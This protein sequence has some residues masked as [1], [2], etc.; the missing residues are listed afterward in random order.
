MRGILFGLGISFCAITFAQSSVLT[1]EKLWELERVSGGKM[2]KKGEWILYGKTLY[3]IDQ[4][5]G[6]RDLY[7]TNKDGSKELRITNTPSGEYNECWHPTTAKIGYLAA[8]DGKTQVFEYDLETKKST[9]VSF[10]RSGVNGFKYSPDGKKILFTADVKLDQTIN[11]KY[12]DLPKAKVHVYDDLM[13]RHWNAWHDY[14]YSH[15]FYSEQKDGKYNREIDI[16]PNEKYDAPLNPF[17]GM[18]QI[19]WGPNSENIYYTCKKKSGKDYAVST[20]SDIYKY[21]IRERGTVNI[22]KGMLG[23]D[24]QPSFSPDGKFMAFLSM[25]EDGFESDKNDIILWDQVK[26]TKKNYTAKEDITVANYAWSADGNS[27]YF[28]SMTGATEQIFQL[29]LKKEAI[30]Q[31]T[32]GQHNYNSIHPFSGGIIATRQSMHHPNE[33]FFVDVKSGTGTQ[34]TKANDKILGELKDIDV[35][36]R[37]IKT[38]DGKEML[39]WVIYPPDFDP[40]KKYPT[41]LYCQ[42]GPQSTVS[43]FFSF[44]WNFRLIA[45][46]G[47]IVVAPNRR[48]LPGFGQEWNDQIS[49]DWGGQAMED[50]LSAIDNVSE[51]EYVD[52]NNLGCIGASYGGYSAYYLAGIHEKRF[53]C[54]ISHCGLFNLES[55]YGSTEELFFANKDIGG[56]YWSPKKPISYEKYSPHKK[57]NNW[58]TPIL[59][60][61]GENDYRVPVTQGME[62]FQVAQLKGIPSK[63]LYFPTEGHWVQGAQNGLVWHREFFSWLDQWLKD[64][65]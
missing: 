65:K 6:N 18:E 49:G 58:D 44:R 48:G 32:K 20:N 23:Y 34:I 2:D 26:G 51:E 4:N 30:R 24:V 7:L 10:F 43:Q 63:F 13:Y 27:I 9:Q 8:V 22:T 42:G 16:M 56:P 3:D 50:Y 35:K 59:V 62:A 60:I 25:E 1:P 61:H 17:G 12:P 54:F 40:K 38:T 5:K 14:A 19:S 15:V 45:S 64:G 11:E 53:D 37:M 55:W 21:N 28:L 39:T 33:L 52:K 41:I 29:D 31:V 47:Y 57:A 46:Q 36:K